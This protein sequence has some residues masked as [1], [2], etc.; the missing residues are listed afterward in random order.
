MTRWYHSKSVHIAVT[1]PFPVMS[2]LYPVPEN[3]LIF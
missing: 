2:F 1:T 3:R